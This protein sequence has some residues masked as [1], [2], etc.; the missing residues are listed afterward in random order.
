MRTI[1]IILIFFS[2]CSKT[3]TQVSV[4]N[5]TDFYDVKLLF[6]RNGCDVYRFQD[7]LQDIYFTT[8][9][10]EVSYQERCGKN[11]TRNVTVPTGVSK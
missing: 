2:S 7:R 6:T 8:C 11:C 3:G 1:L 5:S 9:K 10:G 4:E